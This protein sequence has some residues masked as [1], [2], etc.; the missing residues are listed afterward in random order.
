MNSDFT[1]SELIYLFLDGEHTPVER[2]VLFSSLANNSELQS[3]F[4]DALKIRAAAVKDASAIAPS[5][6]VTSALMSKAGFAGGAAASAVSQG[7]FAQ[8]FGSWGTTMLTYV[9]PGLFALGGVGIGMLLSSNNA[10]TIAQQTPVVQTNSSSSQISSLI[11]QISSQEKTIETLAD[12]NSIL[13]DRNSTLA[14]RVNTLSGKINSQQV[15]IAELRNNA[16]KSLAFTSNTQQRTSTNNPIPIQVELTEEPTT[17]I[18]R[19]SVPSST[20]SIIPSTLSTPTLDRNSV[21]VAVPE[22]IQEL[23]ADKEWHEYKYALTLRGIS[24][25]GLT[26]NQTFPDYLR[27]TNWYNNLSFAIGLSVP[28]NDYIYG[29]FEAGHE[30]LPYATYNSGVTGLGNYYESTQWIAAGLKF[31]GNPIKELYSI[32]PI[33]QITAGASPNGLVTQVQGQLGYNLTNNIMLTGGF[34]YF[35]QQY[36]NY[37]NNTQTGSKYSFNY[38][39]SIGL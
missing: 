15:V 10:N 28:V 29:V 17:T 31:V 33:C 19:F 3:E 13:A 34:G 4:E 36:K 21:R 23:A 7:W 26:N 25:M 39:L 12:R 32:R 38:G 27:S 11:E 6:T 16:N 30:Y 35:T 2:S 14:Q 1:S 9:V 18:T 22:A 37:E 5:A 20:A 24:T 8:L